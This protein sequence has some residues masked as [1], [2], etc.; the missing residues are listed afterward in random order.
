MFNDE[1]AE[2]LYNLLSQV[3]GLTLS[4]TTIPVSLRKPDWG[5]R[6]SGSHM[7]I[8]EIQGGRTVVLKRCADNP[9]YIRREVA[10]SQAKETLGVPSYKVVRVEGLRLRQSGTEANCTMTS[11]WD[12]KPLAAIDY[13][14]LQ[15]AR[16][17]NKLSIPEIGN[18]DMFC[19]DYG[20]WAAFN[21]LLVVR[22]RS[23]NNFVLFVDS[24]ILHSVDCE[25]GP[26]GSNGAFVGADDVVMSTKQTIEKF[27]TGN[28]R[29]ARVAKLREGF[30]EG[31]SAITDRLDSLVMLTPSELAL[32]KQLS[33]QDVNGLSESLFS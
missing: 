16:N 25:D 33:G 24:Q 9:E 20:K 5:S 23:L 31:W 3:S 19:K 32:T 17:L 28:D 4:C 12:G 11:G 15:N 22:D 7:I 27:I 13:G 2:R 21:Y 29:Q 6:S 8:C 1:D 30:V 18:L 10:V 26:F 14:N